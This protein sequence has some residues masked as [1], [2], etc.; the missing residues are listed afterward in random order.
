MPVFIALSILLAILLIMLAPEDKTLGSMQKLIY[1]HG[2]LIVTGLFLFSTAGL[3][4]LISLFRSSS[5]LSFLFAFEK[6]AIIFWV[7]ATIVGDV[8][9]QLV[10]GGILFERA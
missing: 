10:W 3:I 5:T 6:T 9:S 2:A 1:L 8:A 4:A 7:A